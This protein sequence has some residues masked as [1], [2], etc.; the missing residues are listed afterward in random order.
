MGGCY[1]SLPAT[2]DKVSFLT[3]L[4]VFFTHSCGDTALMCIHCLKTQAIPDLSCH[5][6]PRAPTISAFAFIKDTG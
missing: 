4:K 5:P 1:P 6:A 2:T 3:Y